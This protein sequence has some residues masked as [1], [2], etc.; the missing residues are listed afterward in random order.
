MTTENTPVDQ[1]EVSTGVIIGI[2]DVPVIPFRELQ[3]RIQRE[4]PC[5]PVLYIED[6]GR[7]EENPDDP[8]YQE[9]LAEYNESTEMRLIDYMLMTGT[10]IIK[11]PDNI[12]TLESEEWAE[13]CRYLGSD[14]PAS[15]GVRYLQWLKYVACPT[16]NDIASLILAAGRKLGVTEEDVAEA[17]ATF[18]NRKERRAN[19]K[20]PGKTRSQ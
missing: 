11:V 16:Q 12:N 7:E 15:G 13:E 10:K 9:E 4:R 1:I 3:K 20:A 6:K 19:T 17:S 5:V 2:R 8:E 18:Q 14:V